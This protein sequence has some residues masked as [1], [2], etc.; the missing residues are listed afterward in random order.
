RNVSVISVSGM[1]EY[2]EGFESEAARDKLKSKL[3]QI[4]ESLGMKEWV[5]PPRD[6][7]YR[8]FHFFGAT[9]ESWIGKLWP[10]GRAHKN[11][12]STAG[13]EDNFCNRWSGGLNFLEQRYSG[14]EVAID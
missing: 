2:H 5:P 8:Y 11:E 10:R 3:T 14:S 4:F 7:G 13:L 6:E 1:D 9:H 12:L